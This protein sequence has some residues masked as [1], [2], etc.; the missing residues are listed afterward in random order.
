VPQGQLVLETGF[1]FRGEALK[2]GDF[3]TQNTLRTNHPST[4]NRFRA[5][6]LSLFGSEDFS[7]ELST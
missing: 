1:E 4:T 5:V 7:F 2:V 3:A 6:A